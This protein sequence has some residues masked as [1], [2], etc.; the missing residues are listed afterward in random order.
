MDK[1]FNDVSNNLLY[2]PLIGIYPAK[3]NLYTPY[4]ADLAKIFFTI[5]DAIKVEYYVF[6]GSS[7]G[8]LRNGKSIPWVDDYDI[9]IFE[10]DMKK[11]DTILATCEKNLFRIKKIELGPINQANRLSG[12]SIASPRYRINECKTSFFHVDIFI[13]RIENGYI[14]NI[15]E[16]GLYHRKN[17]P[18]N[19]VRPQRYLDFDNLKL[20]FFQQFDKDI[21]LE[22]G[23]VINNSIIHISHGRQKVDL[24][25]NWIKCYDQFY[26]YENKAIKNTK[27]IILSN[28]T[29]DNNI[30]IGKKY[31][32][33]TDYGFDNDNYFLFM[34]YIADNID[35]CK[36]RKIQIFNLINVKYVYD[37]KFFFP[38]I[39]F[40]VNINSISF[41]QNM[42]FFLDKIDS[43][44]VTDKDLYVK[45]EMFLNSITVINKPSLILTLDINKNLVRETFIR[46][47]NYQFITNN[48]NNNN[49][50]FN[51]NN[52]K[53]LKKI[54]KYPPNQKK[55]VTPLVKQVKIKQRF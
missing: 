10:K 16:W 29:E 53:N 28:N 52:I 41:L 48:N 47:E 34:K 37:I 51:N 35:L 54:E 17:V 33:L 20:P 2:S 31:N 24:K 55:N 36:D 7:I 19:Y 22:Y 23:D 12:Y 8:L 40:D 13:S 43:I 14:R 32:F 6:A 39:K 9:I 27:K 30:A 1:I 25:D 49:N 5:I 3:V 44:I 4:I 50:F 42:R 45:C 11:I 46:T 15:N 38:N 18:I 21:A 26:E